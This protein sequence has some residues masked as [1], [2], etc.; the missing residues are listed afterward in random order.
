MAEAPLQAAILVGGTG[1]RVGCNTDCI[2]KPMVDVDGR[3]FLDWLIEEVAHFPIPS[4]TLL[5]GNF[6]QAI[7][8]R[9]GGRVIGGVRIEVL[10]EPE[11][12]VYRVACGC[13]ARI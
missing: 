3:P 10:V 1:A 2:L 13:P 9:Y 12:W 6:G 4:I 8:A 11:P 5:A 7:M